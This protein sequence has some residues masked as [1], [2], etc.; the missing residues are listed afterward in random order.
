MHA[1]SNLG[2]QSYTVYKKQVTKLSQATLFIVARNYR[3]LMG[4]LTR[5]IDKEKVIN[6]VLEFSRETEP[7]GFRYK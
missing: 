6:S 3:L 2:K 5:K 7:V 1:V 4:P